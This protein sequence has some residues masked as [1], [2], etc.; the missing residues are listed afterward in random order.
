MSRVSRPKRSSLKIGYGSGVSQVAVDD[1][2][3]V[4]MPA[5]RQGALSQS[6][7]ALRAFRIFQDLS[8][9]GLTDIKISAPFQVLGVHL[10]HIAL[11]HRVVSCG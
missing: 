5:E 4:S 3:T 1:H 11:H 9:R 2:D 8:R 7:L 10:V 6:I